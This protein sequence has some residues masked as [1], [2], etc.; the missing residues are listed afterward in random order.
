MKRE[1]SYHEVAVKFIVTHREAKRATAYAEADRIT[2]KL[3][4]MIEE[5]I[6]G[7][8]TN[9]LD[10]EDVRIT[11]DGE[12]GGRRMNTYT[13]LSVGGGRSEDGNRRNDDRSATSAA[14]HVASHTHQRNAEHFQFRHAHPQ[15]PDSSSI[16][17][18]EPSEPLSGFDFDEDD[19]EEAFRE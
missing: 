9:C 12:S 13:G 4:E 19:F 14:A 10:A 2:A 18:R 16:E 3:A 8:S 7:N 17:Y 5:A 1:V 15:P 11:I 6:Q